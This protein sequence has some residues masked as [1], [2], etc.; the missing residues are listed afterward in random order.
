VGESGDDIPTAGW[1]TADVID[2]ELRGP[3]TKARAELLGYSE[4][5]LWVLWDLLE[6]L[7]TKGE[8]ALAG[9]VPTYVPTPRLIKD[10]KTGLNVIAEA[11][12]RTLDRAALLLQLLD[13]Q[14][15]SLGKLIRA[16]H[17]RPEIAFAQL[18]AVLLLHEWAAK[19]PQGGP[20]CGV[21]VRSPLSSL[22]P[23][24]R[25]SRQNH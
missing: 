4:G 17:D 3:V 21:G 12:V 2:P 5:E 23:A 19:R 6:R 7:L 1:L 8:Q 18:L 25:T 15:P 11:P 20:A 16:V 13:Q 9:K 24:Y 22:A 10:P 14:H